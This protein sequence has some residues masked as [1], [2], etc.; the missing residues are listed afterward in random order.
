[1]GWFKGSNTRQSAKVYLAH[2]TG[3]GNDEYRAIWGQVALASTKAIFKD[4]HHA[5][6]YMAAGDGLVGRALG[7]D[8]AMNILMTVIYDDK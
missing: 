1:M 5:P 3:L 8:G 2:R 7:I 4:A 6:K